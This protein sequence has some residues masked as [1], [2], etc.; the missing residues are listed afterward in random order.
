MF[1]KTNKT[2]IPEP[3]ELA[4]EPGPIHNYPLHGIPTRMTY[5]S[6]AWDTYWI[7]CPCGWGQ[8]FDRVL[9]S[10]NHYGRRGSEEIMR[11]H[12][13]HCPKARAE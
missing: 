12:Y 4:P 11:F 9:E 5:E 8:F 6:H 13:Q 7:S 1:G 10:K 3:V 2:T